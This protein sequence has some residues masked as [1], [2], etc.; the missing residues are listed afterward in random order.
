[1]WV[2]FVGCPVGEMMGLV[3]LAV[4]MVIVNFRNESMFKVGRMW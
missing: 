2:Q 1:M 4:K 3:Y